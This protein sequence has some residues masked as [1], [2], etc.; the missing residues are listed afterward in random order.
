MLI[1]Y[2]VLEDNLNYPDLDASVDQVAAKGTWLKLDGFGDA[3]HQLRKSCPTPTPFPPRRPLATPGNLSHFAEW[4]HPAYGMRAYGMRRLASAA[5][6]AWI[7]SSSPT[8][9]S[10]MVSCLLASSSTA[11]H[12]AAN[13]CTLAWFS[14]IRSSR[15]RTSLAAS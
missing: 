8:S 14:R 2:S 5:A 15:A 4:H 12:M 6:T 7:S 1:N 9:G 10:R 13:F 3:G 11:A